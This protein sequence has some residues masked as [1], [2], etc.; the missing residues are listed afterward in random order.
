MKVPHFPVSPTAERIPQEWFGGYWTC[1]SGLQ[2]NPEASAVSSPLTPMRRR[3]AL[4]RRR[5]HRFVDGTAENGREY[6]PPSGQR[7][8]ELM[9][10]F[11]LVCAPLPMPIMPPGLMSWP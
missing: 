10:N 8:Q 11:Q 6:I 7:I 1:A 9:N 4:I 5:S 3:A 2:R